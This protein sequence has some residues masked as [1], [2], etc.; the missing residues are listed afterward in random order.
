[1]KVWGPGCVANLVKCLHEEDI[2]ELVRRSLAAY[3]VDWLQRAS[4]AIV[5]SA[6]LIVK[7]LAADS[8]DR[9]H[10]RPAPSP[11]VSLHA[12]T[13]ADGSFVAVGDA[14]AILTSPD[15][16]NWTPRYSS[17]ADDLLAITYGQGLYVAIG[18]APTI[19]T[20]PDGVF[21]TSRD[22]G[23]NWG[24]DAVAYGQNTFVAVGVYG[25]MYFVSNRILTS[26]DGTIWEAQ[27][28]G[29]RGLVGLYGVA[30]GNGSLVAV[31]YDYVSHHDPDAL[32][33]STS[34]DA[35]NWPRV[36]PTF[37]GRL[38]SISFGNGL[39]VA[40][41]TSDLETIL[42]TSTNGT[43]WSQVGFGTNALGPIRYVGG[44]FVLPRMDCPGTGCV[45][46]V[47]SSLDGTNWV[48]HDTGTATSLLDLTFGNGTF[49][50]L[51]A[52][53][54]I[55]QSDPVSNTSPIIA[56]QPRSQR[57]LAGTDVTLSVAA[58]G[59]SPFKYQWQKAGDIAGATNDTLML[60]NI[61]LAD[62]GNYAV[63]INGP[64]GSTTSLPALLTVAPF[65][66]S[67]NL[68]PQPEITLV[69]V[70]GGSYQIQWTTNLAALDG[71]KPLTNLF[72]P[73]SS[74]AWVDAESTNFSTR[75]YRALFLG[76]Q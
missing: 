46:R 11:A 33:I 28:R 41:G 40:T 42:V 72:S 1:M 30:A 39:F 47:L 2:R 15:G 67:I 4:L 63:R 53:G 20:S 25:A 13:F 45:M 58:L 57:V 73:A 74:L 70:P 32:A 59:T 65:Q 6:C 69:G 66:L 37:P 3:T 26:T 50:A 51:G 22:A 43:D 12:L 10:A 17:T 68:H 5:C 60:P 62:A 76:P 16:V 29:P 38:T 54:V 48:A 14:G 19:L 64:F 35:V 27:S 18:S 52:D 61:Q 44:T 71:W 36:G 8:L 21:W 49:L 55:L 24:L 56:L 23:A 34:A 7:G 75:L 31:G 9:W